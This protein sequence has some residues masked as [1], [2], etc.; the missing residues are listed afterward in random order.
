MNGA[1]CNTSGRVY[2]APS[3]IHGLGLFAACTVHPGEL[4]G[5]YDGPRV[6]QDG[7]YVLWIEEEAGGKWI[8]YDGRNEMRYMNH[9]DRPNAEMDGLYCYA[10]REIPR[11]SEITIDYGPDW[12]T[13]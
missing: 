10:L 13:A 1:P 9:S 6:E 11:D 2:V 7:P 3:P 8:G 12:N 5:E 4:I